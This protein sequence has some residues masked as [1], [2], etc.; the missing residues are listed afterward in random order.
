MLNSRKKWTVEKKDL[1]VDDIVMLLEP[2]TP[3]GQWPLARVTKLLRGSDGHIRVADV[4]TG[5]KVIRRPISI[6]CPLELSV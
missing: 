2:G 4:C 1:Q 3:Y 5:H 6:L